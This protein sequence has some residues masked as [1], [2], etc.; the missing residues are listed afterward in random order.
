MPF[1]KPNADEAPETA[2]KPRRDEVSVEWSETPVSLREAVEAH[3][4]LL[5]GFTESAATKDELRRVRR[6]LESLRQ[7]VGTLESIIDVLAAAS[8]LTI[9]GDCPECDGELALS[10]DSLGDDTVAC[11][12][13]GCIAA[14]VENRV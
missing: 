7:H 12:T 14:Y 2:G 5:T 9:A 1:V 11:E 6:E 4:G 8:P 3:D 10:S 13:C